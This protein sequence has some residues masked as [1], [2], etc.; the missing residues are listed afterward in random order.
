MMMEESKYFN[1]IK[2]LNEEQKLTFHVIMT[3]K[4]MYLDEHQLIFF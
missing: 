1:L 4:K 2:K 3:D